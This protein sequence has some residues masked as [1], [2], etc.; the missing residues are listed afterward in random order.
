MAGPHLRGR[1]E[2][3]GQR[4]GRTDK[5]WLLPNPRVWP[6]RE[7]QPESLWIQMVSHLWDPCPHVHWEGK[8]DYFSMRLQKTEQEPIAG[9]FKKTENDSGTEACSHIEMRNR[10]PKEQRLICQASVQAQTRHTQH[11]TEGGE[12]CLTQGEHSLLHDRA[13]PSSLRLHFQL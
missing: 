5:A 3:A 7:A 8:Q 1:E 6:R 13:L 4:W 11:R 12:G 2:A 9:R 10:F